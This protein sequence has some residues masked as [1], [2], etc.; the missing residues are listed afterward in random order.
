[1]NHTMVST[2]AMVF[3]VVAVVIRQCMPHVADGLGAIGK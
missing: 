1:M 2:L 3:E